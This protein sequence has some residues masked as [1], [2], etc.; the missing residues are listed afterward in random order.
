MQILPY[1]IEILSVSLLP[2]VKAQSM[3]YNTFHYPTGTCIS[4]PFI[5]HPLHFPCA[6]HVDMHT[7]THSFP[8]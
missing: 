6:L 8:L 2:L 7:Y 3:A 5:C 4:S 1:F